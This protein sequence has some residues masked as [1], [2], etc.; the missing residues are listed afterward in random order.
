MTKF[1]GKSKAELEKRSAE[2]NMNSEEWENGN[3]GKSEEH[4]RIMRKTSIRLPDDLVAS[5]K[6][7]AADEGLGYQTYIRRILTLHVKAKSRA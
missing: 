2:L 4:A 3:L 1:N 6:A 5:L 7:M